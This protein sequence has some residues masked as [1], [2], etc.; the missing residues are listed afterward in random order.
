MP[1]PAR[2]SRSRR[3]AQASE[4][5]MPSPDH[6]PASA[7]IEKVTIIPSDDDEEAE[8][9]YGV[10]DRDE[11]A[12]R[13]ATAPTTTRLPSARSTRSRAN[14]APE[15][16]AAVLMP[17]QKN[18]NTANDD[19][20]DSSDVPVELGRKDLTMQS[21]LLGGNDH[22][23]ES[24]LLGGGAK[25]N[26]NNLSGLEI[27]DSEIF[28]NLDSSFEAGGRE[29]TGSH[30]GGGGGGG[31]R[32]ADTST[33]NA[34]LF[35]RQPAGGRRRQSSI[36]SKDDAPIRPTSRGPT[37]PGL[38]STLNLG[39]FR[40]RQRQPSILMSSAQKASLGLQRS[41]ATSVETENTVAVE[42]DAE[43]EEEEEEESFLPEAEGTPV[44]LS[45]GRKSAADG[46][47]QAALDTEGG[48]GTR[49]KKRKSTEGHET[50]AAKRR[51]VEAEAEAEAE[52]EET[53]HK[54][55]DIEA[56]CSPL[57]DHDSVPSSPPSFIMRS[58]ERTR[59]AQ[60]LDSDVMALPHD[61]DASDA[62]PTMWPSLKDLGKKR[63]GTRARKATPDMDD[64]M[65]DL[66]DPPSLTHSPNFKATKPVTKTKPKESP[67]LSTADLEALLPRR[68][69][70]SRRDPYDPEQEED[71]CE[72]EQEAPRRP[73]A[74]RKPARPLKCSTKRNQ[75]N[76]ANTAATVA[77][78][79]RTTRRTYGSRRFDQENTAED[80]LMEAPEPL[81]DTAFEA[82]AD[83]DTTTKQ[84]GL[85]AELKAASRKFKEVDKWELDFEE[86][87]EP[88]S[89][90][91]EGR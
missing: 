56:P 20:L 52:A 13:A 47:E 27:G 85:S 68:R 67:K 83:D 57:S 7:N 1:R 90:L 75:N 37:T 19:A 64:G 62:S 79:K 66:S 34:S 9:L 63:S 58:T 15:S 59:P 82:D 76:A 88:S 61:S 40:R 23:I 87:V 14:V 26:S 51:A 11:D 80:D 73:A 60:D 21:S 18:R 44:R 38:G 46:E 65:S 25:G 43:E 8:D 48:R 3:G 71:H 36:V 77:P 30:S 69:R 32:S 6:A 5:P 31:T 72:S 4:P 35:R 17:V 74:K 39:N 70:K 81:D 89:D 2:S 42:S 91:P 12:P 28:G 53:V 29:A 10:S 33:F 55:V 49:S 16:S 41:R 22:V 86:V 78:A 24:S 84:G 50:E 54:S 45:R